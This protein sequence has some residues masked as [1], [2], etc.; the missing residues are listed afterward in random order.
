MEA[1]SLTK[2]QWDYIVAPIL[3]IILLHSG[4]V[5]TFLRDVLYVPDNFTGMGLMHPY[6]W[7]Y[8]KHLNLALKET[9]KP[10]ITANLF[11][12]SME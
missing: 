1:I 12:A 6:Y 2:D 11:I 5:Q 3:K 9:V 10:A 7:Q 4:I 8:L